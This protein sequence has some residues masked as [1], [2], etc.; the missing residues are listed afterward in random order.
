MRCTSTAPVSGEI[1]VG[2]PNLATGCDPRVLCQETALRSMPRKTGPTICAS[3]E[4]KFVQSVAGYRRTPRCDWQIRK[5]PSIADGASETNGCIRFPATL[6][7][8]SVPRNF[9]RS[10][11]DTPKSGPIGFWIRLP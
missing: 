7:S 8:G 6:A 4:L 5:L 3:R 2:S 9:C 1:G 11:L 10:R